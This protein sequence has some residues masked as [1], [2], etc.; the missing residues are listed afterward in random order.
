[1]RKI[2]LAAFIITAGFTFIPNVGRLLDNGQDEQNCRKPLEIS[3]TVKSGETLVHIFKKY[4]LSMQELFMLKEA[5]ASVYRLRELYPGQPY[6]ISFDD[7][8]RINSFVYW[9][10]DDSILNITRTETGFCAEKN[11]VGYEKRTLHVYGLVDDNLISSVGEGRENLMM[12]LQLSDIFRWDI[13]FAADLRKGDIFRVVVDGLFLDGEFKKY[14][15]ILSAEFINNGETYRAYRFEVS[16]KADYYDADGKLLRK[17]FLKAPLNFR[18]IS[19]G[20]SSDRFHPVLK[21]SRPHHGLDFAA[22]VGTPVSAV[23]DGVVVFAGYRGQYGRLIILRHHNGYET[24]Y[25]HLSKIE[26]DIRRGRKVE[27]GRVIGNVGSTGLATGPHLHYE[28]RVHRKPVNPASLK[29]LSGKLIP[30]R[31][32]VDFKAFRNK[33]DTETVLITSELLAAGSGDLDKKSRNKVHNF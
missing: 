9:I 4:G 2:L 15:D 29:A 7:S 25:G 22:P 27:Q 12:A 28:I 32:T 13:D 23:G 6:K 10:D 33:M 11:T 5:S 18:R 21:I 24:Y 8:N 16:G 3:G 17:T 14:G 19:S 26:K 30:K 20:F 31:L 1:M